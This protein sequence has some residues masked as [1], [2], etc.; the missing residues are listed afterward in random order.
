[1]FLKNF[2]KGPEFSKPPGDQADG[3][4]QSNWWRNEHFKSQNPGIVNL[5][6]RSGSNQPKPQLNTAREVE[7]KTMISEI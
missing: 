5:K 1:M 4:N 2:S 6:N 3:G 7:S